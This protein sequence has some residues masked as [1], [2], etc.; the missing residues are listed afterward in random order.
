MPVCGDG[1]DELH[2]IYGWYYLNPNDKAPAW[3]GVP[4]FRNFLVR[5]KPSPGPF[6]REVPLEEIEVGDFLQ[7]RLNK[8]R[9]DHTP[10]VVEAAAHPRRTTSWWPPTAMT[11]TFGP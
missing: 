7:L 6:A 8:D 4:Y 1:S 11:R 10:I 2:A 3:T 9:F 5:S